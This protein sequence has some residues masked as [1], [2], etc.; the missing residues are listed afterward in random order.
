M[1][2][3]QYQEVEI[4]KELQQCRTRKQERYLKKEGKRKDLYLGLQAHE[5]FQAHHNS[6]SRSSIESKSSSSS[7]NTS[8]LTEDSGFFSGAAAFF[9]AGAA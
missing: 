9:S 1:T 2:V 4:Q 7:V 8:S 6:S 3:R 5:F